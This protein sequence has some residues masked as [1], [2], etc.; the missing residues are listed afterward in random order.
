MFVSVDIERVRNHIHILQ[1][2]QKEAQYL[3]DFFIMRHKQAIHDSSS[4]ID[5]IEKHL[6]IANHQSLY[7]KHRITLLES[8][9]DK[10]ASVKNTTA[11]LLEDAKYET[12]SS[13]AVF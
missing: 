5:F 7:I 8:I 2:E 12:L 11:K 9:T 3:V 10:F 13:R 1:E 6:Q 4:D